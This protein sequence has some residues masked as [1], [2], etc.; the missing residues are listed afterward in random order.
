MEAGLKLTIKEY[1]TPNKNQINGIGIEPD[2]EIDLPDD[3][4]NQLEIETEEDTQLQKALD[5]LK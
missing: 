4:Q 2:Y 1:L 5:I 3:L